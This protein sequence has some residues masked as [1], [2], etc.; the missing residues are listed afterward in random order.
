VFSVGFVL[1]CFFAQALGRFWVASEYVMF[2]LPKA[3]KGR[4]VLGAVE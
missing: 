4:I 2:R 1:G 3:K